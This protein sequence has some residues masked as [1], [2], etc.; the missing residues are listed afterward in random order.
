MSLSHLNNH[1]RRSRT[2][3]DRGRPRCVLARGWGIERSELECASLDAVWGPLNEKIEENRL[4]RSDLLDAL[5]RCLPSRA[6]AAAASFGT[7]IGD[8][9]DFQSQLG[10]ARAA[11][12]SGL[13]GAAAMPTVETA[14]PLPSL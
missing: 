2:C 14:E 13:I 12:Q 7:G 11:G 8:E 9:V 6:P 5:A 1:R 3:W 4:K 10:R